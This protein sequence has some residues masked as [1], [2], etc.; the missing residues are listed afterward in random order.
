MKRFDYRPVSGPAVTAFTAFARTRPYVLWISDIQ[1]LR[2]SE[3]EM[4]EL[5]KS[6]VDA[7][8]EQHMAG[9][10]DNLFKLFFAEHG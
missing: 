10:G 2:L 6:A 7:T 9:Q 8:R 5:L 1:G 4:E 3:E